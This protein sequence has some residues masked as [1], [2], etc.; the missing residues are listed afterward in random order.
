MY[1]LDVLCSQLS[2]FMHLIYFSWN[3]VIFPLTCFSVSYTNYFVR[4]DIN[5]YEC[6]LSNTTTEI[7]L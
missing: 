7:I 5:Y 4:K 1:N 3:S 2:E 6:V